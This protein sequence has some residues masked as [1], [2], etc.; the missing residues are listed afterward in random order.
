MTV[1]VEERAGFADDV[2]DGGPADVAQ[3]VGQDVQRAQFSLVENGEQD[4]F[5]VA[6][7]LREDAAPS[8]GLAWAA[9]PVMAE[10]FGVGRLPRVPQLM[11]T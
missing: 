3:E 11:G 7:F 1:L 4:A 9:A 2:S 5:T 8:T 6:D 10:A